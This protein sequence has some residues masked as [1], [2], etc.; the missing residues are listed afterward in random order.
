MKALVYTGALETQFRNEPVPVVG[1]GESLLD[2]SFCG[3]CGSDMHAWHGHDERRVPPLVLGHEAVGR[4]VEGPLHGQLVAINP[5]MTC[6]S[7]S[8]CA[9]GNT[10]LCAAREMIG[11]RRPGGFAEQVSIGSDNLHLITNDA[12]LH[13]V[14][15]S[16]PL[17][18]SVH[19][20]RLLTHDYTA[21]KQQRMVIL[22]G[23]AIGLLCG[24]VARHYG[25][26]D[27]W[28]AETNAHRRSILSDVIEAEIYNPLETGPEPHSVA[29]LMDAVG[30]HHT[31]AAST[32]LISPG[33]RI[34]HIGLQNNEGG[35]DARFITLQEVSFQGTYC[36]R[37]DD[38]SEALGL[39]CEGHIGGQGWC[40]VRP[41]SD[42]GKAFEDIHNGLAMPKII[43]A[44]T[45]R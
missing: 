41:M 37:T 11:M 30:S 7:C 2:I 22:G 40:D 18:C 34:V 31:R 24:L 14:A 39:I 29:L 9:S 27:I 20:V 45:E 38:F 26:S 28:I 5:L 32:S 17:A 36:Y 4:V 19:A 35:L 43:L 21:D 42:G 1:A 33:G 25:Y 16:E 23:G 8:F 10:H 44:N 6:G 12:A 13:D 15:L 3:I